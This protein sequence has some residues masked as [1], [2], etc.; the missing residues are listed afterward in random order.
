MA[1]VRRRVSTTTR[2]IYLFP[3]QPAQ[4]WF[5]KVV[6]EKFSEKIRPIGISKK[7]PLPPEKR[8]ILVRQ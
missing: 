6:V 3:A 2:P 5:K 7:H 8:M 4:Q 1:D